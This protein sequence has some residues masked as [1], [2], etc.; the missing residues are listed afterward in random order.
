MVKIQ[1]SA[2]NS[3]SLKYAGLPNVRVHDLRH[4][5][6][7]HLVM[8]G[9]PIYSVAQLLGHSTIEMISRYSHLDMK[10]SS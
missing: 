2:P 6:D 7:S 8:N 9:T 10:P 4:A 3:K 1:T 5:Y